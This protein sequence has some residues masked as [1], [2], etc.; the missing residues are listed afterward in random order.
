MVGPQ[1]KLSELKDK[2]GQARLVYT[3]CAKALKSRS[4]VAGFGVYESEQVVGIGIAIT[5]LRRAAALET[6][7]FTPKLKLL[8]RKAEGPSELTRFTF[9]WTAANALFAR[10]AIL[11][12]LNP[13]A[14]SIAGELPKF[15]VL[16]KH[17]AIL[18]SDE[19]RYT[20]DIHKILGKSVNIQ[21]FPWLPHVTTPTLLQVIYYKYTIDS[22]KSRP[23]GK[24]IYAAT[25]TQIYTDLDLPI[26][27]YATRNW[28]IHGALI[29]SSF[30]G[31]EARFLSYISTIN[32]ALADV[33][34]GAGK[35]ILAKL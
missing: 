33:L 31:T 28:N 2:I 29:G 9:M 10:P 17:S 8:N 14:G 35:A 13:S 23:I 21:H 12:I 11:E 30:R 5:W 3:D 15:R 20:H 18:A 19:T 22:E 7:G 4:P 34:L 6:L 1:T 26:L 25:Q 16:Y 32:A 27:I 24:K